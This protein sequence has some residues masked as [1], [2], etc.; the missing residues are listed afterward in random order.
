MT[1]SIVFSGTD[2]SLQIEYMEELKT[3]CK[4]SISK[5]SGSDLE[6]VNT[7]VSTVSNGSTFYEE[8]ASVIVDI[9][10]TI[11]EGAA[12]DAVSI[13]SISELRLVSLFYCCSSDNT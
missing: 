5:L 3:F 10:D 1:I 9:L 13:Y 8:S 12:E 6:G 11:I 2:I 7:I 4:K